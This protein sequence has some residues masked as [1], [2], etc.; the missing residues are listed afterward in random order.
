MKRKTYYKARMFNKT[1]ED[2]LFNAFPL[3]IMVMIEL[4]CFALLQ[5][6]FNLIS[7]ILLITVGIILSFLSFKVGE[8]DGGRD[9]E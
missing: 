5:G 6:E 7:I 8:K 2:V 9:H 1:D 4:S 3:L